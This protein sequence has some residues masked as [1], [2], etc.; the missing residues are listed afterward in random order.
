MGERK[1]AEGRIYLTRWNRLKLVHQRK[2][3]PLDI[4]MKLAPEM[5]DE[6]QGQFVESTT[7]EADPQ[8]AF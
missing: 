7:D 6:G 1:S 4:D 2:L 5:P 3:H 8:P